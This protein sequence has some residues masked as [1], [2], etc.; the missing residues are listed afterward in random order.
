MND[1]IPKRVNSGQEPISN[2]IWGFDVNYQTEAPLLTTLID[3]LPFI[4]TKE[5]SRIIATGEFAHLIPGHHRAVGEE[6][7]AYIDDFE[8]SR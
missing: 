2:A 3:K 5:K 7:V 1:H 8:A 6:G 4:E